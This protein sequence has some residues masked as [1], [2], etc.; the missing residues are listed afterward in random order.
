MKKRSVILGE[1]VFEVRGPAEG[2]NGS[3]EV[4]VENAEPED[5]AMAKALA[6]VVAVYLNTTRRNLR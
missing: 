5:H 6:A 3:I 2:R 1:W 4:E